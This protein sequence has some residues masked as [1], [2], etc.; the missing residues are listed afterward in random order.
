LISV[1]NP[2]ESAQE[3]SLKVSGVRL[4][5]SGKLSQIAPASLN[6]ANQPGQRPAV[7]IVEYPQSSLPDT[8]P[9]PPVS[10]GVYEFEIESA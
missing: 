6:S 2:T 7:E 8:V 9:V 10:I 5:G 1:V 3:F 4:R